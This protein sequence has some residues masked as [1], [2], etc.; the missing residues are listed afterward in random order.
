MQSA[1]KQQ[2]DFS[3]LDNIDK[4]QVITRCD[5]LTSIGTQLQIFAAAA[6][7]AQIENCWYRVFMNRLANIIE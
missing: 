7:K 4:L 3:K 2:Y 6:L 5:D 1:G